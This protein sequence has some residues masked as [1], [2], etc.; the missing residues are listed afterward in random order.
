MVGAPTG[1]GAHGYRLVW[2]LA[3]PLE[4]FYSNVAAGRFPFLHWAVYIS[5]KGY[6]MEQM[7]ALFDH[8][9]KG[10]RYS[11]ENRYLG[12]I[13]ELRLEDNHTT[14]K[15][16]EFTTDEFLR[17]F[18]ISSVA[19][20]GKT[21]FEDNLIAQQGTSFIVKT[22]YNNPSSFNLAITPRLP[23]VKEQLSAFRILSRPDN[24]RPSYLSSYNL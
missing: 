6:D 23:S 13:Y 9:Q 1:H 7:G 24:Y 17:A 2:I 12:T 10:Y 22:W 15:F 21:S 16:Y 18:L 19:Y 4:A 11:R 3:R 20:V 8:L 5:P 14:P